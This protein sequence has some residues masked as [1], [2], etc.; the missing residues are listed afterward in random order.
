PDAPPAR[1]PARAAAPRGGVVRQALPLVLL[2]ASS[3]GAQLPSDGRASYSRDDKIVIPFDLRGSDKAVKVTLY[4]SFD[5]GP[6]HEADSVKPGGK[7]EFLFR[8]DRDG[9]YGFATLTEFKD[10][11]TDPA[12]RDQLKEQKRV[13]IAKP[14]PGGKSVRAL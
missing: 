5:G 2:I 8:A 1:S 11:T 4:Y 9:P 13:V 7:R 6:W 12:R 14:P 3:A 10:G